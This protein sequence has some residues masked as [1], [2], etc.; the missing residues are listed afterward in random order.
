MNAK[1]MFEKLDWKVDTD[2]HNYISYYQNAFILEMSK[3]LY[4]FR[5]YYI[6]NNGDEKVG[7]IDMPLLNAIAQQMIE[8]GW[9]NDSKT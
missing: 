9:L 6:D 2:N 8:L 7:W 4:E 3:V 1:E 5:L